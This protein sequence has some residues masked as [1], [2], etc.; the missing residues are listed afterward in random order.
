MT[1]EQWTMTVDT[2]ICVG[3]GQCEM[4]ESEVFHL[5][6]DTG[7]AVVIGPKT[8]PTDRADAAIEKC[9]SGAIRKAP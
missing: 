2:D 5:D 4:L 8:L 9:P 6:D 7:M 3:V 1:G